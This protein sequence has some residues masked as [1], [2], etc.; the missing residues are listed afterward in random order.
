VIM[1]HVRYNMKQLFSG[2]AIHRD[3]SLTKT[4][5]FYRLLTELVFAHDANDFA[6]ETRSLFSVRKIDSTSNVDRLM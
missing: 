4:R 5:L 3:I 6:L 1:V 2:I